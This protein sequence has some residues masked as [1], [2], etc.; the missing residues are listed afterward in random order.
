V[1]D[2]DRR[3]GWARDAATEVDAARSELLDLL[4]R[5]VTTPSVS[6]TDPEHEIQADL[7]AELAGDGLDVDHWQLPMTELAAE[8]DFPGVEVDRNQAWGV[9]GRLAGSGGGRSLM[10]NGHV[11]VVPTG[12]LAAWSMPDPFSGTVRAGELHGRGACDMKAGLAAAVVAARAV[13][14]AGVPLR[15]DLLVA[16]VP[17][18]E[19]GGMG[20]YG[21]LRRGW[22]ADACVVPEPTGLDLVPANAGALTFR[23]RVPG[24]AT[25]ASRR[26][27]GVSA[28]EKFLPVLAALRDLEVRR[29]R[30]PDPLLAR[31]PIAYPLSIGTV[32]SGDWAST[33]PDLL[34][35][36][37]RLGVALDEPVEQ[38]RADLEAAV[39]EACAGDA[40][41]REHPVAVEW[42]GGQFASGRLPAGSD[43]PD[44]VRRAHGRA[45]GGPQEVWA[46]PYGSDLRLL[47]GLGGV[48][49]LHYG[50][51]DSALAHAPD[52][53]VPLEDVLTTAR[54]LALLAVDV[55]TGPDAVDGP[56]R[57]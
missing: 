45:G 18:E 33:V 9:V 54:A 55:C 7:A 24:R 17:A 8:P 38:A 39:A 4:T 40:W 3:A 22:R 15:G 11:D 36:E 53:R 20:T 50:P 21:L 14:R 51:G 23:L 28:L 31:W 29:N 26:T 46:G 30:D 42:W 48:P 56:D 49:T 13:R 25:H 34:E 47:T 16:C 10:L 32:R 57:A 5:L 43:L 12:D 27:E 6:G 1:S 41:L 19:D 52:E 44:R 2:D 35:A 37:G